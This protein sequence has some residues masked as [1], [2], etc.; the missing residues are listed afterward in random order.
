MLIAGPL[1]AKD[2][3]EKKAAPSPAADQIAKI[4]KGLTLTADEKTKLDD[5]AKQYDS[6][7]CDAKKKCDVLTADQK[8]A[9]KDAEK[10]A[11]DA[12]KSHKEIHQAGEAAVTL[13]AEQKTQKADAKK[14][15]ESLE[16]ELKDKVLAVLTPDQQAQLKKACESKKESKKK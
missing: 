14:G 6:K 8:K 3:K 4:T 7:L 16:K 12:G 10:A 11:K 2:K 1:M 9:C 5:V 13:T 15:M